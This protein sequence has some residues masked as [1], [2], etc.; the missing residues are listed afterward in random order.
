LLSFIV[1]QYRTQHY[2]ARPAVP[3]PFTQHLSILPATI[4]ELR[5]DNHAFNQSLDALL[6]LP[7]LTTLSIDSERFAQPLD[8]ISH[9]TQLRTLEL[10]I[11]FPAPLPPL[12]PNLRHLTVRPASEFSYLLFSNPSQIQETPH[13][14]YTHQLTAS[15]FAACDRL[16]TLSI[17]ADVFDESRNGYVH[18]DRV[19]QRRRC[20]LFNSPIAA[21]VLPES[22]QRLR[23][24]QHYQNADDF[25]VLAVPAHC[26]VWQGSH[27]VLGRLRARSIV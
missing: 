7:H 13:C 12:P 18:A 21:N 25:D 16:E 19:T 10:C 26:D 23:L 2:L 4:T 24:P 14:G 15:Q 27:R 20:P 17:D 9:L 8:P 22:L 6:A 3:R 5:I 11:H 1:E